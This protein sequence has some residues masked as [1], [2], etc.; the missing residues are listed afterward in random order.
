LATSSERHEE[1]VDRLLAELD[2][3]G[4]KLGLE[5]IRALLEALGHPEETVPSV[6]VA[7]TN[8]K[9]SV[10]VMLSAVAR[11]AGNR[12][13]LFT[14]P[15]LER[16]E[17]RIRI[18]GLAIPSQ[19]FAEL[20]EEVVEVHRRTL[21]RLPS[22]FEATTAVARLYFARSQL[23]LAVL[24]VGLGGRLDATNVGTPVL[25]V[26]TSIAFDHQ[27]HLGNTLREI[28]L[29]KAGI[30]RSGG[31][32]V[33]WCEPEEVGET[34]RRRAEELE[35]ELTDVAKVSRIE[36]R[37]E[38]TASGQKIEVVTPRERYRLELQL[39]GEHQEVNARVAVV[40]AETLSDLGW[41]MGRE[42]IE[43][44]VAAARWPGRL[45]EVTLP[46]GKIVLLDGAHNGGGAQALAD[47]LRSIGGSYDLLFG[48]LLKKDVAAML[49]PLAEGAA[50]VVLTAP[51]GGRAHSPE[52][53]RERLA[54]RGA[55]AAELPRALDLALA[56]EAE[57]LVVAGS[58]YLVGDV[59]RL[60][61]ERF[62]V[63]TPCRELSTG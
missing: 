8:G 24:E 10:S 20:L 15:H 61:T 34:L 17:E 46:S 18:D 55:S 42:Q 41:P 56:G 33:A 25:P 11:A 57:R 21:G 52:S 32:L 60:L 9:G 40:A 59:R 36:R 2:Q 35:V 30:V 6:V 1:R 37:G 63:P 29:E 62:G 28:T 53:L 38:A 45:E 27:E 47:H 7:G 44:G 19:T 50:R 14:S 31:R 39:S 51:E 48:A 58:L 26:I 3:F 5:G 16:P 43:R 13:G 4:M 54:G 49:G 23:D 12:V 22:Y